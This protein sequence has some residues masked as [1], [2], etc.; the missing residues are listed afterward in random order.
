M[1]K[2][3]CVQQ[4]AMKDAC[5]CTK[6][7]FI[8]DLLCKLLYLL[9]KNNG[10]LNTSGDQKIGSFLTVEWVSKQMSFIDL[11]FYADFPDCCK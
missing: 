7:K 11:H 1:Q 4:Q 5:A 9:L 10:K 8:N 3:A 6:K 2:H